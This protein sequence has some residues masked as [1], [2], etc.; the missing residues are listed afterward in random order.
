MTNIKVKEEPAE[1][2]KTQT[3]VREPNPAFPCLCGLHTACSMMLLTHTKTVCNCSTQAAFDWAVLKF[4]L[5][6]Y[7]RE[8]T[9]AFVLRYNII[10][11]TRFKRFRQKAA[12]PSW[13]AAALLAQTDYRNAKTVNKVHNTFIN[14]IK[15]SIVITCPFIPSWVTDSFSC[16]LIGSPQWPDL[17]VWLGTDFTPHGLPDATFPIYPGS[18]FV[19]L[20]SQN[21]T[22]HL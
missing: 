21:Q 19:L 1:T 13:G 3:C 4:V 16:F 5:C 7:Q 18:K 6:S 15:S 12:P 9:D 14:V 20:S 2:L 10:N 17:H 22:Q 8:L 11:L